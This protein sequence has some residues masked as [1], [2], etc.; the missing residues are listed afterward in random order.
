MNPIEWLARHQPAMRPGCPHNYVVHHDNGRKVYI[1]TKC[2]H[3]I[4]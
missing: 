2:G 4:R 3:T 1:C